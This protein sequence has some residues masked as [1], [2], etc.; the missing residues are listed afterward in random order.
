MSMRPTK[1][2]TALLT[3]VVSFA[4][5]VLGLRIMAEQGRHLPP[6]G[7][8]VPIVFA[9]LAIGL[10]LGGRSVRRYLAGENPKLS[11][12]RASRIAVLATTCVV[13]GALLAGAYAAVVMT[14]VTMLNPA[15][16]GL[17]IWQATAAAVIAAGLSA[18]GLIVER[19]CQLPPTDDDTIQSGTGEPA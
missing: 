19:W 2:T 7:W 9:A 16:Q 17:R 1:P 3:A 15:G 4:V 14:V 5:C 8:H 13:A 18:L 11:G 6:I 10:W 12:I